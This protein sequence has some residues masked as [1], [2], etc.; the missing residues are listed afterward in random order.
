MRNLLLCFRALCVWWIVL[1]ASPTSGSLLTLQDG[2][3]RTVTLSH[4][5]KRVVALS[6]GSI[7]I[8]LALGGTVVGQPSLRGVVV[9]EAIGALPEVGNA[10]TP[11]VEVLMQVRPDLIIA[12]A[13]AHD[14]RGC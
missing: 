9:S 8:V 11:N 13:K 12:P 10:V 2:A 6:Q 14:A 5:A 7:E 4:P 1:W 3:G